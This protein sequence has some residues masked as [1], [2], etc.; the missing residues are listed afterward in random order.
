[1][2]FGNYLN[3][4]LQYSFSWKFCFDEGNI[5]ISFSIN[6]DLQFEKK[7]SDFFN[8]FVS[9]YIFSHIGN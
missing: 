2:L 8:S 6:I 4:F 5:Y 7:L 1:M 9:K 3:L